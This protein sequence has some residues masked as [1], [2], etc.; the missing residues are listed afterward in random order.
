MK[1]IPQEYW[2][3]NYPRGEEPTEPERW[4][5]QRWLE[6]TDPQTS[7]WHSIWLTNT[8]LLL[9]ELIDWAPYE[10]RFFQGRTLYFLLTELLV[11]MEAD[12]ALEGPLLRRSK[13]LRQEVGK[14]IECL[15]DTYHQTGVATKKEK[16][17]KLKAAF[18]NICLYRNIE[19]AIAN[20]ST[21]LLNIFYQDLDDAKTYLRACRN[22]LIKTLSAS[23]NVQFDRLDRL[24]QNLLTELI[25]RHN[26]SSSY[27]R[28]RCIT[29]FLRPN[30]AE[31][32]H[33]LRAFLDG[34]IEKPLTFDVY[35][36]I[37]ARQIVREIGYIGDVAFKEVILDMNYLTEDMRRQG[38]FD[39][40]QEE[41]AKQFFYGGEANDRQVFAVVSD[42]EAEDYG[43]AAIIGLRRLDQ[44]IRQAKFEFEI[45]G[46]SIDNRM[47]IHN[48]SDN[49]LI[50][51]TKRQAQRNQYGLV[52]NPL[53]LE[54][55]LSAISD[56]ET[57]PD[58]SPELVE[59]VSS[60]ALHWHRAGVEATSLEAKFLSHW[61]GLEQ[62]FTLI[63][64]KVR[65]KNS[66]GDK[67][68]LALAEALYHRGQRQPWL[69]LWGDLV[70]CDF[71]GPSPLL[72]SYSGKVWFN[73]PLRT[74]VANQPRSERLYVDP[75]RFYEVTQS[76]SPRPKIVIK[77]YND[78]RQ[79]LNINPGLLLYMTDTTSVRSGQ[80]LGGIKLDNDTENAAIQKLFYDQYPNLRN[81]W[82]LLYSTQFQ[83]EALADYSEALE[84][85][86]LLAKVQFADHAMI[87]EALES[88]GV[89]ERLVLEIEPEGGV[90]ITIR[91]LL[92]DINTVKDKVAKA[93]DKSLQTRLLHLIMEKHDL[94]IR[95]W[96]LY[97]ELKKKIKVFIDKH[98][99]KQCQAIKLPCR[100]LKELYRYHQPEDEALETVVREYP[101]ELASL[102]EG[103]PLLTQ[104]ILDYSQ[105]RPDTFDYEWNTRWEHLPNEVE[106][107]RHPA[108]YLWQADRM[109]RARNGL[110]H[111]VVPHA[112]FELLTQRLYQFSRVYLRKIIG[113][114]ADY[115][116]TRRMVKTFNH[117][118]NRV[119][120]KILCL[121]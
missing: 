9:Q 37:Q 13:E 112:N 64:D 46:F 16:A 18:G 73:E 54:R 53:N 31:F 110:V 87:L 69:D 25:G 28:Q 58:V 95:Y 65:G 50:Y 71:F 3:Q 17:K 104:R 14:L 4:W 52:G 70:R 38:F 11:V 36:R 111:E 89:L 120:G 1:L 78:V 117:D 68:C 98:S 63:P 60:F 82:Y 108:H 83:Q 29:I 40:E 121:E 66:A 75:E 24:T 88:F 22:L 27:L 101:N 2:S 93:A 12:P 107:G 5:V 74:I 91:E 51:F 49:E 32:E 103:Q 43:K 119:T 94:L 39:A 113:R 62:I 41:H 61:L 55:L 90:K 67:L 84:A 114:M 115:E 10:G 48:R 42:I 30:E 26:Y 8:P 34:L 20:K 100:L 80:W 96:P 77:D 19:P 97:D 105:N 23:E 57:N 85:E 92:D 35:M 47:Y 59:K 106:L 109:R 15:K 116:Y 6:L 44:A 56:A 118:G 21:G 86:K 45:G 72:S 76:N 7:Y 99:D 79:T 33:R 102:C 81:V